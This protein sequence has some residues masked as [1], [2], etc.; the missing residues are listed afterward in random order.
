M[1]IEYSS[2]S[3]TQGMRHVGKHWC[4]LNDDV[5]ELIF[6]LLPVVD[7]L[8]LRSVC[9]CWRSVA[10]AHIK[11][12]L[13]KRLRFSPSLF[14]P[15][16]PLLF[17]PDDPDEESINYWSRTEDKTD[18][19]FSLHDK[20][21]E[22][23]KPN[24][25]PRE[26]HCVGS[27]NGGWLLFLANIRC[28]KNDEGRLLVYN[29]HL[30]LKIHLPSFPTCSKSCYHWIKKAIVFGATDDDDYS[31]PLI[32]SSE[33][34]G[35]AVIYGC[36]PTLVAYLMCGEAEWK[37][38]PC[39][40]DEGGVYQDLNCYKDCIFAVSNKGS[41]DMWDFS[42]GSTPIKKMRITPAL[43]P[44]S[45]QPPEPDCEYK[46]FN[47]LYIIPSKHEILLAKRCIGQYVEL[48]GIGQN[49]VQLGGIG[50]HVEPDDSMVIPGY[51]DDNGVLNIDIPFEPD[52]DDGAIETHP[53]WTEMIYVY[54][55]NLDRQEWIPLGNLGDGVIFV[56]GNQSTLLSTRDFSCCKKN[57]VYF[58]DDNW[59]QVYDGTWYE[60]LDSSIFNLEDG[61]LE[62]IYQDFFGRKRPPFWLLPRP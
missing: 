35:I 60:G 61:S 48:D 21:Y 30:D 29:P 11:S 16:S 62:F 6:D 27:F 9:S 5:W 33:K 41:V 37:N 2:S 8:H 44:H 52:Y 19:F 55:L 14:L 47:T 57:S 36:F 23:V 26:F 18:Y 51:Y 13:M 4:C 25:I 58:T 56:G 24:V 34:Y 12:R 20:S 39:F 54:T 7:I 10:K 17:L 22:Q 43:P 46:V 42:S 49:V 28:N 53:Y 3:S 50:Q 15:R 31:D 38:F 1:T 40:D 45:I 32:S 59:H